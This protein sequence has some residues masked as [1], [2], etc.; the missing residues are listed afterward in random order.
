[1][2][3]VDDPVEAGRIARIRALNDMLRTTFIGGDVFITVGVRARGAEFVAACIEAMRSF[4]AFTEENDPYGEHEFG[5]VTV[6]NTDV[7]WNVDY[8]DRDLQFGSED[9][10]DPAK[11]SRVLTILLADEY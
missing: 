8:Y 4:S 5:V 6:E 2:S 9:P 3:S 7:F 1:M 11:T 10:S